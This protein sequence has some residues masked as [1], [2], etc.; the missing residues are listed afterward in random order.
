[1]LVARDREAAD[2]QPVVL[3]HEDG[4]VRITAD[5]AEVAALVGDIAPPV[6]RHEPALRLGTDRRA[7]LGQ[8]FGVAR[9][10][11]AD[12]HSTP[13]PAPPRRGSPAAASSPPSNV[14]AD[15]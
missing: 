10:R 3:R 9:L 13:T 6:R 1:M 5:R 2:D 12:D 8:P 7:E 15:A 14:T 11:L 4:G